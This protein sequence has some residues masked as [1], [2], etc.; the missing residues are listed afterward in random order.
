MP[1][2]VI[3]TTVYEMNSGEFRLRKGPIFTQ[4]LLGDEINRAPAKNPG[5]PA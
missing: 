3:G 5:G 4:I 1:S 2:D